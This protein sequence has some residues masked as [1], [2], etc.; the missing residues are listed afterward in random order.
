MFI[1]I[2]DLYKFK[3]SIQFTCFVFKFDNKSLNL[4]MIAA[5]KMMIEENYHRDEN[6]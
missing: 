4:R 1:D 2:D 6:S 3:S 5:E